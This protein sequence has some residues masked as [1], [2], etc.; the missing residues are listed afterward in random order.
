MKRN[1]NKYREVTE[2]P[3]NAVLPKIY[4]KTRGWESVS[5]IYNRWMRGKADFEIVVFQGINFIIP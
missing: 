4:A 1:E 3:N 5:S 2:L